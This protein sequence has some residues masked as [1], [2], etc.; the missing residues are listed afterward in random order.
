MN[1]SFTSALKGLNNEFE[2]IRLLGAAGVAAYIVGAHTFVAYDVMWMKRPFDLTVYCLTFPTG[3]GAVIAAVAKAATWKDA[4]V[5][6]AK[7]TAQ[8]G[9]IPTPALDGA[10]V[11]TGDP[12]P[13]DQP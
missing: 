2:V 13:V 7:V 12:P 3:L 6:S 1:W 5:A 9:A 8:T 4:G 11:P 10:R